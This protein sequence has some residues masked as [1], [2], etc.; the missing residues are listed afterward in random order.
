W[1]GGRIPP[2][3]GAEE[4][5]SVCHSTLRYKGG[6]KGAMGGLDL[7]RLIVVDPVGD[8]L[9]SS[10]GQMIESLR[11][12]GETGTEPARRC[13][14]RKL[15]DNFHGLSNRLALIFQ[16]MH[17]FLDEAVAHELPAGFFRSFSNFWIGETNRTVDCQGGFDLVLVEHRL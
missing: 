1:R 2:P 13:L 14:S 11:C 10:L 8:I 5:S 6:R 16:L 3:R 17:R 9:Q 15:A 12:F 7:V 4:P